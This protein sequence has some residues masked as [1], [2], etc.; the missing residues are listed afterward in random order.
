MQLLN[1][2]PS[3][4]ADSSTN[5]L[6]DSLQDI[7]NNVQI[8][9]SFCISHPNYKP[10]ELPAEA[11]TRFQNI[12]LSLQNK[13]LSLQLRSF[14]YG[15]YYNGSLQTS[16]ALNTDSAE[17]ALHQN[18]ENNTFLGVNLEFYQRLHES[19]K[20]EGY[21]DPG[22]SVLRQESDGSFAV[23]KGGL[24]L[25]IQPEQHLQLA[26]HPTIGAEVA[27]KM[28]RNLV[29]NG[30]YMAVSNAGLDYH[31]DLNGLQQTVRI[32]FNL[33]PQGAIAVMAAITQQL[34][35]IKIPFTFKVLY[36]P[37]DYGR[38][39]SGVL[40][41]GKNNYEAVR[42]VLQKIYTENKSHFYTKVPLF[43][44]LLAPGLG[45][46]EEP[47]YK[48][49]LTESFGMNRCQIVAN[50]LIEAREN[51]D[52]SPEERIVSILKQFSSLGINWQQPY[53]NSDSQDIYTS[54]EL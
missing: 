1:S 17:L 47:D 16:L 2:P 20:G 38:H 31:N 3:Q 10:L 8:K 29:Q 22:W 53:L 7:A 42:Q 48:F 51:G 27:I 37:A 23:K 5:Q 43:T 41:F 50:G 28:P 4:L 24:T 35:A 19:N 44:K 15:I 49:A 32:Y 25:H 46:A 12:P 40:Y 34:N 9:S 30:F 14:L 33:S 54:L 26:E 52:D 11:V 13:Y 21:F 6:L 36:N 45:L 39:D 18:L